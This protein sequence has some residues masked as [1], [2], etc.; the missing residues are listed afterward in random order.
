VSIDDR[1]SID[2]H[3]SVVLS[4]FARTLVTDFPIQGILD[5]LVQRIVDILPVD[6][7]GVSLISATTHPKV[8]ACSD[9]SA[10][11][12]ERLQTALGEGPCRAAYE[13]DGPIVIP[14]LAEDDRFPEF[15][16]IALAGGLKAV[17]TFPLRY[18]GKSLGA[19]DLYRT[20]AG[21]LGERDMSTAQTLADVATAYL[22][23][24]K[25]RQANT[26]FVSAVSHELRTPMTTI[27]GLIELLQDG[28]A[29][30]LTSAQG[31]F[32]DT[33]KR[34]SDRLSAL[35]DDLLTFSGLE[36]PAAELVQLPVDL[37]QVI[38]TVKAT[39]EPVIT[40]SRVA[41][42]FD[43]PAV[44]VMVH[45]DVESLESLVTNLLTNAMKFTEDGG[46]I[47]C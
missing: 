9:R 24:A 37:T 21:A 39:L 16:E 4:E 11:R 32:L 35:A 17:F 45:G 46:W 13:T 41:V 33:M 7:A 43:V 47:L 6:A 8:I 22:L 36:H 10:I 1:L 25:A 19:L 14:N 26:D 29:G 5:H 28:D 3:L 42:T 2:D 31:E 20:T 23:N 34:N 27:T 38:S 40:A 44:P 12:Y 15:A 18:A 30:P